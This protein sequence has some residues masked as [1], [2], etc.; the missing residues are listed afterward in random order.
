MKTN[1]LFILLLIVFQCSNVFSQTQEDVNLQKYWYYRWRLVNDFVKVGDGVGHSIPIQ[2][3]QGYNG[4]PDIEVADATIYHGFYLGILATEFKLLRINQRH[5][6][7]EWTKTEL[8]Y[9]IKAFERLD[10]Y[11]E[12]YL[13]MSGKIDGCFQRDDIPC[14]FLDPNK[15][16]EN[17]RHFNQNHHVP[18]G[19]APVFKVF[20][21]DD[22]PE[23]RTL[24]DKSVARHTPSM[25]QD[26]VIWL[27][28]GFMLIEK[29]VDGIQQVRLH[30][31]EVIEYDFNLQARRHATNMINYCKYKFPD[32]PDKARWRLFRP[33]GKK[34]FPGQNVFMFK[35]PLSVIGERMYTEEA[36]NNQK[37]D[38]TPGR[39]QWKLTRIW[40]PYKNVNGQMITVVGALSGRWG[41]DELRTMKAIEK[42]WKKRNWGNFYLPLMAVLHDIDLNEIDIHQRIIAD[43]SL[44][45]AV[46]PYNLTRDEIAR[47]ADSLGIKTY[48]EGWTRH[49]K[50]SSSF[51]N[52][53][54]GDLD[55]YMR[56]GFYSGLD[57]M[58]L[59]N[60]Y[61]LTANKPLPSYQNLIHRNFTQRD[62][63]M[64]SN[65]ENRRE[66][67]AFS[68]ITI[69]DLNLLDSI[70]YLR[71]GE[72]Y[73]VPR[74]QLAKDA[75]KTEI[76]VLPFN[77]WEKTNVEANAYGWAEFF[78]MKNH[79]QL[80]L[81][82]DDVKLKPKR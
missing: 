82:M 50:Y 38:K 6:D 68:T 12:E 63:N 52:Q 34:I 71:V 69:L 25:S 5:A 43:L 24:E 66:V 16:P 20:T 41:K 74:P 42:T 26:Q 67:G 57:Y 77:P 2:S 31:G 73:V 79:F 8:Y 1:S 56:R 62:L 13:G 35:Y 80:M 46:G 36:E 49:L 11:G 27:L 17:Y 32:K 70:K 3:R 18:E 14:D 29:C 19:F 58:L 54:N 39:T 81:K 75:P 59:F 76:D 45:P 60:L 55:N 15:N 10:R 30:N 64:T 48:P 61:Y 53:W 51:E 23:G 37:F 33:D 47:F 44:A 9:A 28:M 4:I 72:D 22:C 40:I 65:S 7:L 78:V 21:S